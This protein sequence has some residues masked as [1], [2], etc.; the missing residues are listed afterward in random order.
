M[1]RCNRDRDNVLQT[2]RWPALLHVPGKDRECRG[3]NH[4]D[5][6][7]VANGVHRCR[8]GSQARTNASTAALRSRHRAPSSKW[9]T[10]HSQRQPM[11]GHV[12]TRSSR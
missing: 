1:V 3:R 9:A 4:E 12:M 8:K 2:G 6:K 5:Q 10:A 7:T 11:A